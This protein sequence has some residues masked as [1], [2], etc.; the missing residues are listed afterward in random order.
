MWRAD[1]AAVCA[2]PAGRAAAAGGGG[3][4]GKRDPGHAPDLRVFQELPAPARGDGQ[5]LH[6]PC[7]AGALPTV[8][9]TWSSC[10]AVSREAE[11]SADML[12][13]ELVIRHATTKLGKIMC[14]STTQKRG[15]TV[16]VFGENSQR[17]P[18]RGPLSLYQAVGTSC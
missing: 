4:R 5:G 11:H 8:L 9:R 18:V 17:D 6:D 15:F 2:G 10:W 3:Q 12:H 14:C 16:K 7:A 13:I 1:P